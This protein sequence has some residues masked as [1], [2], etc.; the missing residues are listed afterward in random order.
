[1]A[2]S[3]LRPYLSVPGDL[4]GETGDDD[5]DDDNLLLTRIN[6]SLKIVTITGY[7]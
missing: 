5:D 3:P 6:Y 2:L 4:G 1:V 7:Y